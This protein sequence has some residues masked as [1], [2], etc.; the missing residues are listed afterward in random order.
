[1]KVIN[2]DVINVYN[3]MTLNKNDYSR[4]SVSLMKN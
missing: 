3:Q 4:Y 2:M 1:M